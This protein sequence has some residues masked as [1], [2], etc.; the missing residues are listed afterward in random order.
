ME[1]IEERKF[2]D[3]IP[4]DHGGRYD[5]VRDPKGSILHVA[6]GV[7]QDGKN[8]AIYRRVPPGKK[9]KA[10]DEGK[11]VVFVDRVETKTF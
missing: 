2:P 11:A 3:I 9:S 5:L 10:K 8:K 6:P 1:D 7:Y 4:A